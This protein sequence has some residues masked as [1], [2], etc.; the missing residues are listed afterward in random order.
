MTSKRGVDWR[1]HGL[2]LDGH[3]GVGFSLRLF[4]PPTSE[5][6]DSTRAALRQYNVGLPAPQKKIGDVV[7]NADEQYRLQRI[8][9][10]LIIAEV[11]KTLT[12]GKFLA[13]DESGK[14][15]ELEDAIARARKIGRDAYLKESQ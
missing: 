10:P 7:L 6:N 8:T 4:A 14:Q 12:T 5:P 13:A 3:M 2:T 15:K 11:E 1:E 9:G